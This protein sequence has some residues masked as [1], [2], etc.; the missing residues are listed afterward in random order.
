M[1]RN[2]GIERLL[3]SLLI[4]YYRKWQRQ[5]WAKDEAA[6]QGSCFWGLMRFVKTSAKGRVSVSNQ[7]LQAVL[8]N[9]L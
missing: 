2:Q 5:T 7:G 6:L 3:E 9:I 8:G 4:K 1:H